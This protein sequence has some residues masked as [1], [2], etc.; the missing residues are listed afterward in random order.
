M[1][2]IP[3]PELEAG[4]YIAY[5]DES[6]TVVSGS[7]GGGAVYIP[8]TIKDISIPNINDI[9]IEA[10]YNQIMS[11]IESG[12]LCFL[13]AIAES[14]DGSTVFINQIVGYGSLHVDD[15]TS[16]FALVQVNISG[17]KT[18]VFRLEALSPDDY[19]TYDDK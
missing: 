14:D 12:K 1:S 17:G 4:N 11:Y 16:Y 13:K 6:N 8:G 9:S 3:K 18:E 10:S 2:N 7:G 19:L 15:L 5:A